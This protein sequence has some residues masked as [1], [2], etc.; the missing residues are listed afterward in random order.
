M[1]YYKSYTAKKLKL[2]KRILFFAVVAAL[3][4][5]FSLILGNS[6]KKDLA[7]AD[8][9]KEAPETV[10]ISGVENEQTES[11]GTAEHNTLTYSGGCIELDGET[12]AAGANKLVSDVK[13][14]GFSAVSFVAVDGDGL[15]YA[16]EAVSAMS[17][18]PASE[19]LVSSEVLRSAVQYAKSMGL[20]CSAVMLAGNGDVDLIIAAE[21]YGM[22]FDEIIVSGFENCLTSEGGDITQAVAYLEKLR[23][24]AELD[25]SLVLSRDAYTYARNSYHIEKL[26][27]YCEFLG[28]DMTGCDADTV[29]AFADG[30]AGSISAYSLRAIINAEDTAAAEALD[31]AG[32]KIYQYVTA[33]RAAEDTTDE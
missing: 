33:A 8:I 23:A 27:T 4:F 32:A 28:V 9:D 14:S 26:F 22:G 17:R 25:V 3:I 15:R 24:A 11:G 18:L 2:P 20:R 31:A 1:K 6:L 19:K 21:L 5:V 7:E 30:F 10:D 13:V 16:S 12:D 29:S